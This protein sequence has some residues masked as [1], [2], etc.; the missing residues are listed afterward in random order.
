MKKE[1]KLNQR[2]KETTEAVFTINIKCP[3]CKN[4]LAISLEKVSIE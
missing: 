4:Y 1:I 2:W 3:H